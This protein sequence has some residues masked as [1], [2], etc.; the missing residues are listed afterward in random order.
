MRCDIDG[1]MLI[2]VAAFLYAT[3]YIATGIFITGRLIG[4]SERLFQDAYAHIRQWSNNLGHTG[5]D[6]R[7]GR[8]RRWGSL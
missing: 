6:R 7:L 8:D 3:C 2:F 4:L 5:A 1:Y